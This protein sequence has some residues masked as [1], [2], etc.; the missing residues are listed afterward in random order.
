LLR[1]KAG[2]AGLRRL[3]GRWQLQVARP[4]A[5]APPLLK[6]IR[7][8]FRRDLRP[9]A[10]FDAPLRGESVPNSPLITQITLI[11]DT[12]HLRNGA[13][14]REMR[15]KLDNGRCVICGPLLTVFTAVFKKLFFFHFFYDFLPSE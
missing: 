8:T 13:D 12:R 4:P 1:K 6:Q 7:N 2:F 3:R 11:L 15:T 10:H 5:A 9:L 14:L